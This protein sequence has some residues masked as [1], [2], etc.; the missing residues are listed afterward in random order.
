MS[1]FQLINCFEFGEWNYLDHL[2]FLFS[3]CLKALLKYI[4]VLEKHMGE[5]LAYAKQSHSKNYFH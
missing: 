4:C 1:F 2:N 3:L 5:R